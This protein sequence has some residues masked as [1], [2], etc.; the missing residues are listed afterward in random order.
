MVDG[1]GGNWELGLLM[2]EEGGLVVSGHVGLVV[3]G[4]VFYLTAPQWKGRVALSFE[5]SLDY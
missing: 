1:G 3:G 2:G 5:R 4:E